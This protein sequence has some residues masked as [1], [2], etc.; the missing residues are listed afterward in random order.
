M[1]GVRLNYSWL[2]AMSRAKSLPR[3]R[4]SPGLKVP[5]GTTLI[6]VWPLVFMIGNRGAL[7]SI[8]DKHIDLSESD[9]QQLLNPHSTH[10]WTHWV[11]PG[12]PAYWLQGY[13]GEGIFFCASASPSLSLLLHSARWCI[14]RVVA[15][16][17]CFS[18]SS[19]LSL[20]LFLPLFVLLSVLIHHPPFHT[21]SVHWLPS[22]ACYLYRS[23]VLVDPFFLLQQ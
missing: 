23:Q 4:P 16:P 20:A 5:G 1:L 3:V 6:V 7:P 18:L 2:W 10:R 17:A 13:N 11:P 22:V 21:L 12:G 15:S 8:E 9:F 19:S 14:T